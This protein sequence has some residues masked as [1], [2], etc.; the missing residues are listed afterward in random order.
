MFKAVTSAVVIAALSGI[1]YMFRDALNHPEA[2][3]GIYSRR[4]VKENQFPIFAYVIVGIIALIV[5]NQLEKEKFENETTR[6]NCSTR[7]NPSQYEQQKRATTEKALQDLHASENYKK[8]L[9]EKEKGKYAPVE[10]DDND[11]I[12]LSDDTDVEDL[13]ATVNGQH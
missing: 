1:G 4:V 12:L 6:L 8:Y 5:A 9:Q 11:K 2:N 13:T 3:F 7:V 10:L